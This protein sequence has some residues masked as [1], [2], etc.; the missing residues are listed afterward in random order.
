MKTTIEN[1]YLKSTIK[2]INDITQPQQKLGQTVR[3]RQYQ[4]PRK[5]LYLY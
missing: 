4:P 5:P 2:K 1:P 3:T